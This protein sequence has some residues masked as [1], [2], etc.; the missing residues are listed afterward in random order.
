MTTTPNPSEI[1]S[2]EEI[3]K[4]K[5]NNTQWNYLEHVLHS[6]EVYKQILKGMEEYA[7]QFTGKEQAVEFADW[8]QAKQ[9]IPEGDLIHYHDNIYRSLLK[10][11]E[12]AKITTSELYEL[13]LTSKQGETK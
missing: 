8:L 3:L 13:Y 11:G 4:S 7:S 5:L 6:G 12:G 9:K 1:K 10:A 2:A